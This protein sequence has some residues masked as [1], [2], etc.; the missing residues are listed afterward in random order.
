MLFFLGYSIFFIAFLFGVVIGSFL[1]VV[2]LRHEKGEEVTGRSHCMHCGVTLQWF[3]LV[4]LF[5]YLKQMGRCGNC[6]ARLSIQYPLVEFG[7]GVFF[8]LV[9]ETVLGPVGSNVALDVFTAIEL[10]LHLAIWSLF[11]V[12]TVYDFRTKLIPDVFSFS[13]AGLAFLAMFVQGGNIVMPS[14]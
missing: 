5:S 3:E 11:M 13:L 7:S 10:V 4:P 9:I 14:I 12:I 1:N 8:V 2:V 6:K